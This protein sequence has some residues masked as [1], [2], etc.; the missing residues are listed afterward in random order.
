MYFYR[1][2]N[3]YE[4]DLLVG[5][6]HELH[7]WEAK[8][9]MT[10]VDDFFRGIAA[11]ERAVGRLASK[12]VIYAGDERTSRHGTAVIPWRQIGDEFIKATSPMGEPVQ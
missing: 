10:V 4:V 7:V 6:P 5:A 3:G 9:A 8:C 2:S 1:D 11:L 12:T